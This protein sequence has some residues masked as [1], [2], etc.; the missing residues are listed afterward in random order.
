MSG[1]VR[2]KLRS[3][4]IAIVDLLTQAGHCVA[5]LNCELRNTQQHG[6]G[7]LYVVNVNIAL[8]NFLPIVFNE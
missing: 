8:S 2:M 5:S 4:A 7:F 1:A 3:P 6:V